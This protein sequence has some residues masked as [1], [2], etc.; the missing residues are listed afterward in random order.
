MCSAKC[1][2]VETGARGECPFLGLFV[3]EWGLFGVSDKSGKL[4]V[5]GPLAVSEPPMSPVMSLSFSNRR[6]SSKCNGL[7]TT[8]KKAGAVQEIMPTVSGGGIT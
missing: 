7:I 5:N 2:E 8:A 4:T 3:L 6:N 1:I